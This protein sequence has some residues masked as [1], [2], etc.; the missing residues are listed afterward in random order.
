MLKSLITLALLACA[1]VA[2]AQKPNVVVFFVDDMGYNE[3]GCYGS[4]DLHTPFI[5]S[6]AEHG[7][8]CTSGYV[9]APSCGPSRAGIITG[10]YQQRFGYEI[11]PEK[12][13]RNTFGWT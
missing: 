3:L 5:D 8:R 2:H 7:V 6:L 9:T 11:N 4:S 12:E 13:F 1:G 10:H